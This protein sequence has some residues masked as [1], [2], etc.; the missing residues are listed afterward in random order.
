MEIKFDEEI[1]SLEKICSNGEFHVELLGNSYCSLAKG[2]KINCVWQA[3]DIDHNGLY[4]CYKYEK[5]Y[6]EK[7]N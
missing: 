6:F 4:V 2:R 3:E 1:R 5:K 7:L